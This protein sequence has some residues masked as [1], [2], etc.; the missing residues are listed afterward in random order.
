MSQI[1]V[2]LPVP[3]ADGSGAA[4]DVSSFGPLKSIAV[5]GG[6][7]CTIVIELSNDPGALF[8]APVRVFQNSG[9]YT[10]QNAC[11][12]MRATVQNYRTGTPQVDVGGTN[13]GT[14]LLQLTVPAGNGVGAPVD[15]SGLG[16]FKTIQ[17]GGSFRGAIN[18]EISEDGV[19]NW[20][21][22]A[23][24]NGPGAQTLAIAAHHARVSRNGVPDVNPGTPICW[25]GATLLT[26]GDL[27][28][29]IS[30]GSQLADSGTVKFAN[31]N[32]ITF[33]MSGSSQITAAFDAI[34]SISAGSTLGTG[35]G[36]VFS[37]FNGVT[38]GITGNTLTAS[39]QTVGGTAT[40]V[41]ISAG[42]EV[43]TTG[44]VVFSNSNG[45]T[46]GLHNQ[47]LT[48]SVASAALSAGT[49]S[50]LQAGTIVFSNSNSVSFG[51]SG[52]TVT[53]SAYQPGF[54]R[55]VGF[56][57]TG[58]ETQFTVTY[59]PAAGGTGYSVFGQAN[60][61]SLIP[62]L[63]IPAGSAS[64]SNSAFVVVPSNAL[65]SGDQFAF[66]LFSS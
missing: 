49:A 40:G 18:V 65:A 15:V 20:A 58:G 42:T 28:V 34:K 30:A 62:V 56:T 23:S 43:A 61:V 54:Q 4:V 5:S 57:A 8:W 9:Q 1:F 47:T 39:V 51:L 44:A 22:I 52:S 48:A 41:A 13:E 55:A 3:S 33:G 21:Q 59:T 60:G 53:A 25:I 46:F 14:S 38:F 26:A 29:A 31:S 16:L 19:S 11:M 45:I 27:G 50:V 36:I 66:M 35:P 64:R 63:D 7:D 24:F 10:V 37:N 32:G 12:W 6:A 17:I 2:N